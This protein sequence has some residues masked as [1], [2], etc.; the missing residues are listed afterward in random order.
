MSD[1]IIELDNVTKSYGGVIA[2]HAVS[3]TVRARRHHRPDRP[4]RLRQDHAV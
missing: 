3:L 1:A 4:Q 2:N